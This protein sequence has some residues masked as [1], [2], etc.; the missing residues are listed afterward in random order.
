[1]TLSNII[2]LGEAYTNQCVMRRECIILT[3]NITIDDR[4]KPMISVEGD[5]SGGG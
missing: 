1:M 3:T 4:I 2:R 5:E